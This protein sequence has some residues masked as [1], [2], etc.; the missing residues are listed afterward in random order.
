MGKSRQVKCSEARKLAKAITSDPR[1][2]AQFAHE[3]VPGSEPKVPVEPPMSPGKSGHW[4]VL[5]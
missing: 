4:E 1:V 2:V 3:R 5:V